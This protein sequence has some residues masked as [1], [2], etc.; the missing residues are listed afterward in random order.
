MLFIHQENPSDI[1]T[2][3]SKTVIPAKNTVKD[4]LPVHS[5][6][7]LASMKLSNTLQYD[8]KLKKNEWN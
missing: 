1:S 5:S 3:Y 7:K 4:G 2:V 8:K 6:Q